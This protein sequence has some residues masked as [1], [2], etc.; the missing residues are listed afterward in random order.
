MS[1]PWQAGACCVMS[2]QVLDLWST[3]LSVNGR[4][5]ST[6]PRDIAAISRFASGESVASSICLRMST[7][8]HIRTC[9]MSTDPAEIKSLTNQLVVASSQAAVAEAQHMVDIPSDDKSGAEA[10]RSVV[11]GDL[12]MRVIVVL[13]SI[14][15]CFGSKE[16]W[17]FE[18]WGHLRQRV[19]AKSPGEHPDQWGPVKESSRK[20]SKEGT[21]A[22]GSCRLDDVVLLPP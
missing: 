17:S 3:P 5:P 7:A 8:E 10:P 14:H 4:V 19:N 18:E 20:V 6:I 21:A 12:A 22:C 11:C 9:I 1:Q 13:S 16:K 2:L 15:H